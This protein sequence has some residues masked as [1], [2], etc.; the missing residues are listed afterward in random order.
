MWA[1]EAG[2]DVKTKPDLLVQPGDGT[3]S[4]LR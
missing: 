3:S 2:E 1:E 4:L